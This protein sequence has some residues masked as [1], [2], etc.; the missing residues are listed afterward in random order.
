MIE[1]LLYKI[2]HRIMIV[3]LISFGG[4]RLCAYTVVVSLFYYTID[5]MRA[6]MRFIEGDYGVEIK[7]KRYENEH[8]KR[9]CLRA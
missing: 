7:D 3:I 4:A 1:V 2:L 8:F 5:V 9:D 6:L